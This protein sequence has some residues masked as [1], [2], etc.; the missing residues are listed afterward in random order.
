MLRP[1]GQQYIIEDEQR[2]QTDKWMSLLK[3]HEQCCDRCRLVVAHQIQ[4]EA[5]TI[6]AI[7]V[8]RGMERPI[9]IKGLHMGNIGTSL[10][11]GTKL[12]LLLFLVETSCNYYV[13]RLDHRWQ[14]RRIPK[15]V[16]RV[17]WYWI[18]ARFSFVWSHCHFRH[19]IGIEDIIKLKSQIFNLSCR[20]TQS[21]CNGLIGVRNTATDITNNNIIDP[22][23]KKG[24]LAH[25]Y[26]RSCDHDR[27]GFVEQT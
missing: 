10:L 24:K 26:D 8:R 11:V 21:Y 20:D 17:Q 19:E 12:L 4:V 27:L 25:A 16:S 9:R 6:M 7:E 3:W 1:D 18:K 5:Q 23:W 14:V 2:N 13:K 22:I 15:T